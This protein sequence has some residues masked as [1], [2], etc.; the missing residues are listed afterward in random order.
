M[1]LTHIKPTGKVEGRGP[2]KISECLAKIFYG[3]CW[4]KVWGKKL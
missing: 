2:K 1:Q 4:E 3:M